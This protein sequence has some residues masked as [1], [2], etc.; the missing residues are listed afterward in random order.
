M[1]LPILYYNNQ[2]LKETK[3]IIKMHDLI[4][5][6][7]GIAALAILRQIISQMIKRK[8]DSPS[9]WKAMQ[10]FLECTHS[11]NSPPRNGFQ[12]DQKTN[13][14]DAEKMQTSLIRKNGFTR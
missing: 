10:A 1:F 11:T 3:G 14:V 9:F 12:L 13:T 8:P 5:T 7:M 2:Q 6:E 4:K